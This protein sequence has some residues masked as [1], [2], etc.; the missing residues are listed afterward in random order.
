MTIVE[1][2]VHFNDWKYQKKNNVLGV[3]EFTSGLYPEAYQLGLEHS[4]LLMLAT[5]MELKTLRTTGDRGNTAT[6]KRI[7]QRRD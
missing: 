6:E 1:R 4:T 5:W 3:E 2:A 7:I